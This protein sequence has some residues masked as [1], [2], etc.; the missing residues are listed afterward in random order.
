MDDTRLAELAA[1]IEGE[2]AQ[3]RKLGEF[4]LR[5][6]EPW[7]RDY[8]KLKDKQEKGQVVSDLCRSNTK[9]F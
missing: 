8:G 2:S 1:Y 5:H 4:F 7:K 9:A 3:L 6:H